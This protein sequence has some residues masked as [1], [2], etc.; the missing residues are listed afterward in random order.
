MY[1]Q[2]DNAAS[3]PKFQ[4]PKDEETLI[5]VLLIIGKINI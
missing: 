4:H 3:K 2:T 1:C 5:V